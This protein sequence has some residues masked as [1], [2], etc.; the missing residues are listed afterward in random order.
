[1][2]FEE[3]R[4]YLNISEKVEKNRNLLLSLDQK[5]LNLQ[6]QR[7]ALAK[8]IEAQ[9]GYLNKCGSGKKIAKALEILNAKKKVSER[10]GRS[11][12]RTRD[13]SR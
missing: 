5:I 6:K 10:S 3:T 7:A 8:K 1:M 4:D 12:E 9:Q 2:A 11:L 13:F